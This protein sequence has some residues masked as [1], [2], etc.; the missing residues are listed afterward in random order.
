MSL[1][2]DIWHQVVQHFEDCNY[3]GEHRAALL[4][5][6]RTSREL[7]DLALAM[8]WRSMTSLQPVV[9]VINSFA[10]TEEEPLLLRT[11]K[12]AGYWVR[13]LFIVTVQD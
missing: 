13:I 1:S 7:S 10:D 11:K 4:N 3:T 12:S 5:M 2:Y 9:T 8:L 6:A